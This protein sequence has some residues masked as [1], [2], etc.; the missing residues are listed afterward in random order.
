MNV[1]GSSA[2]PQHSEVARQLVHVSMGGFALLLR[3]ITWPQSLALAGGAL[4][5]NLLVLPRV[6][7]RLYRPGDRDVRLHGIL[8]YPLSV[9]ILLLLFPTRLDIV[10]AAWGILAAGDG[11]ATLAGRAIGSA[12]WPWN[13]DKT[14]AGTIAFVVA[15][16]AA[17]TALALWCRP[18][19][20]PQTFA[21]VAVPLAALTAAFVE[22]MPIK[23]DDNL[24][25]AL[26]AGGAL[27][28]V[29]LIVTRYSGVFGDGIQGDS[30]QTYVVVSFATA[31]MNAA[32][33]VNLAVAVAG[34]AARTVSIA[35]AVCGA[36][37]GIAIYVSLGWQG[38]LLLLVTFIAASLASR[39]GLARKQRLGIAEARGGR[40]GPG[41][42][43]ANTGVAAIAAV[44]GGL[45]VHPDL[46]RLAF[47]AALVT[48]G[49]DTI[50]SE[51]GKAIGRHTVSVTTL[52]PVP[53]GT[54][55]A[56]SI[57]G[58]FAGIAGALGLGAVAAALG[59]VPWV[60][61]AP[62]VVGA[63]AGSLLESWL[64]ATLEGPG[65]LNND[66]LNFINSAAG[67]AV[68]LGVWRWTR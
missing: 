62:I 16:A 48:A 39:A 18:A 27:W 56:M 26:S 30:Y 65:I 50:A 67:V 32:L 14:V 55:G 44:L 17:G 36:I 68:T 13:P 51:I 49:S 59:I 7:G 20:V 28:I 35:G 53:P 45:D 46:A 10:A 43:I 21:L 19:A 1:A 31:T 38:W 4:L 41:N 12:R 60:A 23:L 29:A 33:A 25:V 58:T 52:R 2:G 6:A 8:Y 3:W 40:R 66:V 37:I 64:G 42:A 34:Y 15:G 11:I 57:E 63:T 61:L 54:S 9:L 22:T 5:F 24:S 47:A